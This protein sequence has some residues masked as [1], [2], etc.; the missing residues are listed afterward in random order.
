MSRKWIDC[1]DF[2]DDNTPEFRDQLRSMLQDQAALARAYGERVVA[3]S[4]GGRR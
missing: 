3:I 1:R 2:P 4:E